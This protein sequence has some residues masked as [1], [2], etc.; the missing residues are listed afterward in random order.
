MDTELSPEQS[1]FATPA[2]AAATGNVTGFISRVFLWMGGGLVVSA[3]TAAYVGTNE[4]LYTQLWLEGGAMR[5]VVLFAPLGI[6]FALQ[7]GFQRLSVASF[8]TLYVAFTFLQ[9]LMLSFVFQQ[10]SNASIAQ[11]FFAASA[12]FVGAGAVGYVTKRD[13]SRL[14]LVLL[15]GLVGL[16]AASF[17]NLFWASSGLYWAVTYGGVILFTLLAAY[18]VWWVKKLGAEMPE[19]ASKQKAALLGAVSLYLDFVN[20]MLFFLRIF[21]G[22]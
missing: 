8:A 12:A 19:G 3:L 15:V 22:R 9:G 1:P 21:G 7:L 6:L 10:Y 4:Q 5:W 2:T 17:V 20:L 11:A 14:R 13:L 18:D 16:V